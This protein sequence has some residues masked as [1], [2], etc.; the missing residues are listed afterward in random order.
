MLIGNSPAVHTVYSSK[1]TAHAFDVV[2]SALD[3]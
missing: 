3:R 1:E 2:L